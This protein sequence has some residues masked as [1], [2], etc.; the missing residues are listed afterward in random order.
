VTSIGR[1]FDG[2]ADL[3]DEVRPPYPP[4]LYDAIEASAG[5][6]QDADVLDLAAGT[7]IATRELVRRGARVVAIDPGE[8]MIRCLRRLSPAVTAA[9]ATAEQLPLRDR[10]FDLVACATAWHWLETGPAVAELR[11]VLRPRGHIALWWANNRWGSGVDWEDARSEVYRRWETSH[12]SRPVSYSGVTPLQAASDLRRR[13]LRVVFE[14][15]FLWSRERTREDHIRALSTHSDV[16]ALGDQK[17]R[18]LDEVAMALEPWP[19]VVER[20]WGPLVIARV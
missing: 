2:V 18:F 6:L 15:E 14:Q 7:G 13:G 11:R 19:V 20:L 3:Y 16:I 9:I 10:R 4:D 1:G 5:P 17:A 12:G 8:P